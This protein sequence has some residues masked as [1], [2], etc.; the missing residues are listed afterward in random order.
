MRTIPKRAA[1]FMRTAGQ[2]LPT[3]PIPRIDP[4]KKMRRRKTR[5]KISMLKKPRLVVVL[6]AGMRFVC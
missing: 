4:K 3:P 1:N 2:T 6:N 5:E